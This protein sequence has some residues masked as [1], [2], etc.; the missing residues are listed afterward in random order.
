MGSAAFL[1]ATGLGIG[2]A[3]PFAPGTF[4]SLLGPLLVWSLQQADL[5][6]TLFSGVGVALILIGPSVTGVAASRLKAKDPGA[7]VYDE[8]TAFFVVFAGIQVDWTTA[9]VGFL[10]FR[11]FDITKPW[12]VRQ[13]EKLPDGWGIMADDLVA[14][15]YAT[16]ALR[17]TMLLWQA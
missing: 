3:S 17:L 5:P 11:L 12:P 1:L 9:V 4:G 14:A 7:V 6:A 10:W 2:V 13:F 15:A 8:I 16:G